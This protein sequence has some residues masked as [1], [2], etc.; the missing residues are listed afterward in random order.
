MV[1]N[2]NKVLN[3]NW[4]IVILVTGLILLVI[5]NVCSQEDF[6]DLMT[7]PS[8]VPPKLDTNLCSKQCCAQTQWPLPAELQINDMSKEEAKK[9]IPTNFNCNLGNGSGCLCV[10]SDQFNYLANRGSN[11]SSNTCSK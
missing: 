7:A 2:N 3:N 8:M 6:A 4:V 1:L 5:T 9:Y 10:T 11:V